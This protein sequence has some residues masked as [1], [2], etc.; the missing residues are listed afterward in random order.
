[1]ALD[2]QQAVAGEHEEVL[3]VALPVVHAHRFALGE[4]LEVHADLRELGLVPEW[5]DRAATFRMP[6]ASLARIDDEPARS[7]LNESRVGRF[8]RCLRNHGDD[9]R[10]TRSG[11]FLNA[12]ASEAAACVA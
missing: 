8:K 11:A 5:A 3:L 10:E 1:V 6:P 12:G 7:S 9:S 2:Q 4:D